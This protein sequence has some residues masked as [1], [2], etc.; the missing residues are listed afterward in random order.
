MSKIKIKPEENADFKTFEIDIKDITWKQR[1]QL[2]DD[3]I[4]ATGDGQVPAF[5]WWGNIVLEYTDLKETEV[6]KYSTDEIIAIAQKIFDIANKK[7]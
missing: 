1:C 4:K 3:M 7:K 2:N 5:S 6:N